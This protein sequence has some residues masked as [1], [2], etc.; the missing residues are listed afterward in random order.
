MVGDLSRLQPLFVTVGQSEVL[1]DDATRIVG[2]VTAAGGQA[3]L[4]RRT[5]PYHLWAT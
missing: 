4:I 5:V 2:G 1:L 3:T